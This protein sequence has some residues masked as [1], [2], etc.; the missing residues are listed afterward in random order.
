MT[1]Y[2]PHVVGT[3]IYIENGIIMTRHPNILRDK[4]GLTSKRSIQKPY[5][6]ILI[7]N[8]SQRIGYR[9]FLA[10]GRYYCNIGLRREMSLALAQFAQR[11]YQ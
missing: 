8:R 3:P 10:S 4:P 5:I 9:Q 11:A 2:E 6:S 1:S 7:R